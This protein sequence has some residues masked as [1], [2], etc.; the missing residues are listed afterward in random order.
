MLKTGYSTRPLTLQVCE[1]IEY[2]L[3]LIPL[4]ILKQYAVIDYFQIKVMYKQMFCSVLYVLFKTR[5]KTSA[6]KSKRKKN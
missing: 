5:L 2:I 3:T 4:L 1:I 6:K